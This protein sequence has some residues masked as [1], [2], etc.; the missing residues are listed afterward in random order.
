[1]SI[2]F[3]RQLLKLGLFLSETIEVVQRYDHPG[4]VHVRHQGRVLALSL[5]EVRGAGDGAAAQ[6][7]APHP[8]T[9]VLHG[10]TEMLQRNCII[11]DL[12]G[13]MSQF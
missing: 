6:P 2:T 1:M 5:L 7:E 12:T 8:E 4:G 11:L 13:N 3:Y 10:V 9:T